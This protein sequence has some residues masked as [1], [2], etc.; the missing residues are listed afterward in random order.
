M[1]IAFWSSIIK[2]GTDVE[3]QPPEGYVLNL[4]QA[5]LVIDGDS[6]AAKGNMQLKVQ[7]IA[8]DGEDIKSVLGTLRA[9]AVDQFSMALVF[10]YDVPVKFSAEGN[11]KNASI[12]ISGYFQPGPDE[13]DE[14]DDDE[15]GMDFEE[16]DEDADGD[17]DEGESL[18][19]ADCGEI[20]FS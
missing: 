7:T 17:V 2:P 3:V 20:V 15:D 6:A 13:D 19:A 14:D 8:I 9:N 1:S 16:D 18:A 5:A 12:H 4:Q 11:V 10:G